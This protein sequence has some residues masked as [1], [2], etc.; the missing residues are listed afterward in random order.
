MKK[1]FS[2]L[3]TT[4]VLLSCGGGQ[5][6]LTNE[7]SL[8]PLPNEITS[9]SGKLI[10]QDKVIVSMPS[11]QLSLTVFNYFKDVLKNTSIKVEKVSG[12]EEASLSFTIDN[13]LPDEAY[14]LNISVEKI[15]IKSNST[16]AGFF[17]GIQTL[18]QLMPAEIHDTTQNNITKIELPLFSINDAPRFPYRGAMMDVARNFLP[19]ETVLKFIDM[20]AVYK[21]NRL[22]MHLTDDQGWR[23]EIKK[24]PKLTEI[25]SYRSQTQVG[26]SDYYWP[27][28]YDGIAHSGFYTQEDIKEIVQYAAERFITVIPEIEMPGHTSASLAAYPELSCGLGKDYVVRDYFDIFDEVYCPKENTF[29]FLEDVLT[30]VI[31]LFPSHYIHIGGDECPKKAWAKCAH[32]QSLIKKEGLKDEDE[33]QSWFIHRIEK[34]VNSKGRDIIG[35]DEILEGGLAPNATVMSWR[36][37]EGGII[38]AKQ[39]HNVIMTPGDECYFDHYQED[40]EFAPLAMSG[41]LPLDS[42]YGYNP[43]PA[44][45]TAEEQSYIIGTQANIWGEYIQTTE[46]FEYMTFP[47]L[48]AMAEVQW[49]QPENKD[50]NDFT[51]RVAKDFKRLDYYGVNASRNFYDVNITGAWNTTKNNFE[52]T[53]KTFSPNTRIYY[54][55]N[56][57]IVTTSSSLYTE[58]ISLKEDATVY[59]AVYGAADKD[60]VAQGK[61]TQKSFAVNK[62]T[63]CTYVSTPNPV[64]ENVNK[65]FGLID[66]I[67]GYAK[68]VRRW[69]HYRQDT[70]QIDLTLN[71]PHMISE[72]SSSFVWRPVNYT[73]PAR[74]I[75]VS[76]S[77]DGKSYEKLATKEFTYDLSPTEGTR[78]PVSISFPGCEA[79]FVRL[80]IL[81]WGIIP[82]GYYR[83]GEQSKVALDEIEIH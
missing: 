32:C 55:I 31:D 74:K 12:N 67:R 22:H 8:I 52:V 36:G 59:A 20:M 24:Y 1:I 72:V 30:E 9:N 78:F 49:T 38:A 61:T 2:V 62:A 80:E 60:G 69:V 50:F 79:K 65:G 76:S 64:S 66:G 51:H 70:I 68:N 39:K 63:G 37:E 81:S 17:Y 43:L 83:A 19:K 47:R 11:G 3:F 35:W 54:S 40:P 5:P 13:A 57:S 25:G 27:L 6:K 41:F 45:L 48:L 56:D 46:Y 10:L 33:L 82:D 58:T 16:G 23:I 77:L 29:A 34:F 71:A 44:E 26:H 28:R 7:Y 14:T 15:E 73:W 18:I 75:T 53:L 21:L 42:V 4:L